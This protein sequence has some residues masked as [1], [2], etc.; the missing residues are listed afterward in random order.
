MLT[1]LAIVLVLA[2]L[3]LFLIWPNPGRRA[4]M[5]AWQ[6]RAFAHRGLHD[7]KKGIVENTL[8]AF[9]AA[10]EKGFGIE[11]D[12]QFT[13]DM[14]AVVFHDDDLAR[15]TGDRRKVREVTLEAL[16]AMPLDG[17]RTAR[18]PTLGE[19][20]QQIDGRAPLLI[21]LK[22]GQANDR[23]CRALMEQL[24]GYRGEY[25]VES[26]SPLIVRWFKKHAPDV[27]R[28]QLVCAA[29][30]Y[31]GAVNRI[32]GFILSNL[33]LNVLGRPDFVAYDVNAPKFYAPRVQRL[34]FRTPMAAWTVR[35][36]PVA[37]LV[38]ARGEMCIFEK[39][40]V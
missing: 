8:P 13:R 17:V 23:L 20:L 9:E 31:R 21:E 30:G 29:K 32:G 16:R 39:I 38:E 12:I 11:L 27:P 25:I 10:C 3:W 19:A 28:G 7:V 5:A 2:A 33:L 4:R 40:T 36:T 6:G 1:L 18:V 22:N 15:L 24:R 35:T 26:F 34:L 37:A 14:R